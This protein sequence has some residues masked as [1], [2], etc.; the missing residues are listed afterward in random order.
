MSRNR[1]YLNILYWN[2]N[3]QFKKVSLLKLNI[4]QYSTK[5]QLKVPLSSSNE[6]EV[7]EMLNLMISE[8]RIATNGDTQVK[9][10]YLCEKKNKCEEDNIWRL[11]V[12]SNG[13]YYCYRCSKGGGFSELKYNYGK[14]SKEVQNKKSKNKI[15]ENK[16]SARRDSD[17]NIE[18][19][20]YN[21]N[22]DEEIKKYVIPDQKL[23]K[24]FSKNLFPS[25]DKSND[26]LSSSR[27]KVLKYLNKQRGLNDEILMKYSVGFTNQ[28]FLAENG[29]FY[30]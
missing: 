11:Y 7:Q 28:Q 18:D 4:L 23:M 5:K 16:G 30:I 22:D 6:N 14:Y 21:E 27:K 19:L 2:T 15:I 10:C 26:S 3:Q 9:E 20:N 13:S 17:S 25:E 24:S 29:I 12:R 8:K 1:F